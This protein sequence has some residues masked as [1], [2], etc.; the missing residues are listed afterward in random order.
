MKKIFT[1]FVALFISLSMLG[2]CTNFEKIVAHGNI[3]FTSPET[4]ELLVEKPTAEQSENEPE[5][6]PEPTPAETTAEFVPVIEVFAPVVLP[7]SGDIDPSK[8]MIALTF[9]D[10]PSRFTSQILDLLER[11]GARATFFVVGNRV[12]SNREIIARAAELGNEIGGHSWNHRNLTE[13]DEDEIKMQ[14]LN[15]S[16]V[17]ESVTGINPQIFRPPFGTVNDTLQSV[18]QTLNFAIIKWSLDTLDWRIRDS[19]AV[20]NAVMDNATDRAIVLAHDLYGTTA[21]AME[22][23]V[24]ALISMGFQLVTVSEL[25]YHSGVAVEAGKVYRCGNR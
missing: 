1:G 25:M 8:P 24:P 14:L 5:I 18:S 10:G 11:H 17:I 22:Y 4:T 9:D 13:L 6:A 15:T 16:A 23:I 3:D 20:Y 19:E 21:D 7:Q 2:S 12:E